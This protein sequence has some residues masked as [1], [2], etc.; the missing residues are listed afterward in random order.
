MPLE[1][2]KRERKRQTKRKWGENWQG[3][4]SKERWGSRRYSVHFP[5]SLRQGWYFRLL[6]LT[7]DASV[8]AGLR[9]SSRKL[10]VA[11]LIVGSS[12]SVEVFLSL[13]GWASYH[14]LVLWIGSTASLLM[15][16]WQPRWMNGCDGS[17][18]KVLWRVGKQEKHYINAS[19]FTI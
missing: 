9:W 3:E 19:L 6:W 17:V 18:V 10:R 1:E 5:L 7:L 15:S 4:K 12:G 11:C 13:C 16:I 2:E 8:N 14:L